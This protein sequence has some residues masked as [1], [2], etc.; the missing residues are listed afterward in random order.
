[1]KHLK[2][3]SLNMYMNMQTALATNK[4]IISK[5]YIG[6]VVGLVMVYTSIT[7]IFGAGDDMLDN[8]KTIMG[9]LYGALFAISTG[10]ALLISLIALLFKMLAANPRTIETANMWLKRVIVTWV[11]INL[12]GFI[13]NFLSDLTEGGSAAWDDFVG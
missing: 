1:M 10:L 2:E 13:F 6:L 8:V 3:K 7:T 11:I 4:P 5:T 12:L 9:D